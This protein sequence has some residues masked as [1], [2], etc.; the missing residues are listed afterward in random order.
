[1]EAYSLELKKLAMTILSQMVKTLKMEAEVIRDISV[2][3]FSE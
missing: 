2:L 1:M 3:R